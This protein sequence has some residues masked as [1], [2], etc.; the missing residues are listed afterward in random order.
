[1][2]NNYLNHKFLALGVCLALGMMAG[3]LSA[4][5]PRQIFCTIA[6]QLEPLKA[7]VEGTGASVT[8]LVPPG[9]SPETFSLDAA[10][11]RRLVKAEL[12]FTIG[13]PFEKP[14]F[15]KL[16]PKLKSMHFIQGEKGMVFRNF[17]APG[18][19]RDPHV[20]LSVP[21]MVIFT[22]NAVE[23][24]CRHD[25]DNA[26]LYRRNGEAYLARLRTLDARLAEQLLPVK[27]KVC[28]TYH[29]AFGYFLEHYGISQRTVECEG[30]E[31][32]GGYLNRLLEECSA[33]KLPA[34]FVQP[35]FNVRTA[36]ALAKRLKCAI[37]VIDPLPAEL[38]SGLE[39]I[40]NAIVSA[41]GFK[42]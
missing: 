32:P 28:L 41:Y 40:A 29:P 5:A 18:T 24:L 22:Q 30:R 7:V 38:A 25:A 20:W 9:A 19:G 1:M 35:Q 26:A 13:A 33:Q 8:A 42:R 16:R 14:L 34:L 17:E 11:L 27:G 31:P 3:W 12:F 15:E 39:A 23:E 21:N 6:P 10:T 36:E 37:V 2:K 4:A